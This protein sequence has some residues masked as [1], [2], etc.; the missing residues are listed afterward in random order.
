MVSV[1]SSIS[2]EGYYIFPEPFK[3]VRNVRFMLF[4]KHWTE[5]QF[6]YYQQAHSCNFLFC[7]I[8]ILKRPNPLFAKVAINNTANFINT[9]L[10]AFKQQERLD[11]VTVKCKR[12]TQVNFWKYSTCKSHA[13]LIKEPLSWVR[14]S[15]HCQLCSMLSLSDEASLTLCRVKATN[16]TT[17]S[18]VYLMGITKYYASYF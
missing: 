11:I 14:L 10:K 12:T 13:K 5:L 6:I 9:E 7:F 17:H 15:L 16:L 3:N 1:V 8:S 4:R 18:H 2:V